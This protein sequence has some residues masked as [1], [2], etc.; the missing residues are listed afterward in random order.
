MN[1]NL[2][3]FVKIEGDSHT[4]NHTSNQINQGL[5]KYENYL[6]DI[7]R[8]KLYLDKIDVENETNAN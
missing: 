6:H 1:L 3:A 2:S 4:H 8:Y 7:K 5:S